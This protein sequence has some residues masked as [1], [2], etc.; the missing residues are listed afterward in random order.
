MIK[1]YDHQAKAKAKPNN[2]VYGDSKRE[3]PDGSKTKNFSN[4]FPLESSGTSDMHGKANSSSKSQKS[5]SKSKELSRLRRSKRLENRIKTKERTRGERSKSRGRRFEYQETRLDSE[6]E[7]A[8]EDAYEDLNSPYKRPNPTPFTPRITRFNYHRRAK[9]PRNIRVYEGNKNSEDHLSIFSTAAEQEEW[10]M[11]IWCKMFRQ[12]LGGAAQNWFNDLDP[13]SMDRFEELSQKFLEEFLQQK[14]NAKDPTEIYSIKRRPSEEAQRQNT[15][16]GGRNVRKGQSLHS[17]RGGCRDTFTPLTENPKEIL[18]MESIN[19]SPP[20]PL[21]GTPEKHNL[22]KFCDYHEDRGHNTNDCYQLKKQIEEAVASGKLAH[23]VK[24]IRQS[25]QM[26]GSQGRN[27][28]KVINMINGG[29]N[30]KRAYKVKKMQVSVGRFLKRSIPS[31]GFG[32][33]SGDHGRGRKKQDCANR[34]FN[35]V[36]SFTIQCHN[37]KNRDEKIREQ[38]ILQE[39]NNPGHRPGKEPILPKKGRDKENMGEK[40]PI[41]SKRP[42]QCITIEKGTSV[43]RFVMEHQLKTYPSAEPVAHMKRPLTPDRRQALKEKVCNWLKEGIIRSVQ[44]PE[45]VTNA[46]LIKLT[47]DAWQVQMDYSKLNRICARHMYPF[48]KVKEGLAS[49]MG[50]PYT[51]FLQLPKENSQIRMVEDEEEKTGFHTEEGVYYFTHMPKGLKNLSNTSKDDRKVLTDQK[52]Q[53]VEV[54]LEEIVVK[55]KKKQSLI[56]DV[57]EMFNK[58]RRVNVKIDPRESTFRMKEGRDGENL[59]K[60]KEKSDACIFVVIGNISQSIRTRRQLE[61]DGELCMFALSVSRTEPKNIK[62]AIADSAWFEAMQEELHQFH[63]LDVW[64]LV[65][66]PLCKNII[67]MKWL[68]KNKRDEE[69]IVIRNKARLVAKRYSKQEGIDFEESFALVTR[70]KAVQLFVVYAGHKTSEGRSALYGLEQAPRAWYVELSNFLVSK[71]FSKDA[72]LS[73]TLVDQTKYRSMVGALMY[74]IASRPD[75][76]HATCYCACYQ[77]RPTEKHLKEV[78][79]IFWYLKNTINM[80]LWYPKDTSFELTAFSDLDHAGCLDSRK[81]TSGGIQF[82]RGDKLVSW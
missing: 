19:F 77:A 33:P 46:T 39:R 17:R 82:L 35:S 68:W 47:S 29:R 15:Q 31:L 71:G 37:G 9:L 73:E 16:D 60:M 64:E 50:Y 69:N 80:G 26:N 76:V 45:W 2:L 67:N 4:R 30:R 3:A 5:L 66:R 65:D 12:S 11:P 21:I 28:V 6:Y 62:E 27:S 22:N 56:E 18:A 23:L 53:N 36:V 59:D 10:P 51:C 81:S 52:S 34:I 79:H 61:T 44:H 42:D 14:R 25:S 78:K 32:R 55:C 74:L 43:S 20:P 63:R 54:Y 41:C 49:L 7:E 1:E 38:T 75:I 8:L 57:E 48:L 72:D 24:D 70:L 13:K 58:L 40:V